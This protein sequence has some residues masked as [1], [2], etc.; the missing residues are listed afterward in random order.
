MLKQVDETAEGLLT[1]LAQSVEG[2]TAGQKVA[3]WISQFGTNTQGLKITE[4][5]R[6]SV[7]S[8]HCKWLDLHMA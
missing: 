4:N 1:G 2:S 3:D 5:F 8:L 6:Y 7:L